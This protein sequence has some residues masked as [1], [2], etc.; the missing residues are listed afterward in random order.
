MP[1]TGSRF[2]SGWS[3]ALFGLWGGRVDWV[4]NWVAYKDGQLRTQE[5]DHRRFRPGQ[6]LGLF[7]DS[8]VLLIPGWSDGAFDCRAYTQD[9]DGQ[10]EELTCRQ[11]PRSLADALEQL[12]LQ[13]VD[14]SG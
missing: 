6:K 13:S 9:Q 5:R 4:G 11:S 2:T 12:G 7:D 14:R 10:P 1:A 3:E 8:G